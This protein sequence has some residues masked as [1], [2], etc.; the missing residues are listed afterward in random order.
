MFLLGI[1]PTTYVY[2]PPQGSTLLAATGE[3]CSSD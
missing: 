1:A 2:R 3:A